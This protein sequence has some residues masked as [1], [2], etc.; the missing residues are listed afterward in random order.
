GEA[1]S[2]GFVYPGHEEERELTY[3]FRPAGIRNFQLS[4]TGP[5]PVD[6]T[7]FLANVRRYYFDDFVYGN[8]V[9][10]PTGEFGDFE[11]VPLGQTREWSGVGKVTNR[12]LKNVDVSYQGIF[13]V[14]DGKRKDWLWRY[15]PDGESN[16]HTY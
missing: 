4:L 3:T 7:L 8:R 5:T 13:N 6:Q 9:F 16:Q 10:L 12:S 11:D 1:F 14:L 15:L 2:G